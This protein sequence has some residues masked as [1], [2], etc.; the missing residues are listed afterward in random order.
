MSSAQFDRIG[1]QIRHFRNRL[2]RGA[3]LGE[4]NDFELMDRFYFV[5]LP[6][7]VID[8]TTGQTN[9]ERTYS[10]V[11]TTSSGQR[12]GEF[13]ANGG[14]RMDDDDSGDPVNYDERIPQRRCEGFSEVPCDPSF[15]VTEPPQFDW[16]ATPSGYVVKSYPIL[17]YDTT[18]E[19][20]ALFPE[21]AIVETRNII[22]VPVSTVSGNCLY[23]PATFQDTYTFI[24]ASPAQ[25]LVVNTAV[26]FYL[27][28]TGAYAVNDGLL[29]RVR[30]NN[31][32]EHIYACDVELASGPWSS[33]THVWVK[34]FASGTSDEVPDP[35]NDVR[36]V[37]VY[38]A[39]ASRRAIPG[40]IQ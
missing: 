4:T 27:A 2:P 20:A 22:N 18:G 7:I 30:R 23:P 33:A 21:Q 10:C 12:D 17:R 14:C 15:C 39:V 38:R 31:G 28:D 40:L 37:S 19:L 26:N 1:A 13:R 9:V 6:D 3:D 25:R 11:A 35:L 16:P 34:Y 24:G 36:E 29:N 5:S 8:R 32:A